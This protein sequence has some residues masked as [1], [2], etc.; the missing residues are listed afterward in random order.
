M[1]DSLIAFSKA[2][3]RHPLLELTYHFCSIIALFDFGLIINYS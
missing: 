3:N 1:I 2:V